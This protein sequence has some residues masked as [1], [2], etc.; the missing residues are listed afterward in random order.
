M[1]TV[2]QCGVKVFPG[3]LRALLQGLGCQGVG[4]DTVMKPHG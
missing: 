2:E 3:L 1:S 4:L